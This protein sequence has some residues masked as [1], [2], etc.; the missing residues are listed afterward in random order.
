[1][2][3]NKQ[4]LKDHIGVGGLVI[5]NDKILIMKHNKFNTLAIPMGKCE[6]DESPLEGLKREMK[7]E[8]DI[9]VKDATLIKRKEFEVDRGQIIKINNYLFLIN[10]IEG[11]IKNLEPKKHEW[12]KMIDIED[13]INIE[14]NTQLVEM[15][16]ESIKEGLLKM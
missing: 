16:K 4:D 14:S 7:E 10:R 2:R 8:L 6:D 15:A 1:M 11:K 12:I 5:I 9:D 13:F 3:F